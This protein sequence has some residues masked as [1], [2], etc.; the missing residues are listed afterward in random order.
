MILKRNLII[1]SFLT[2][3]SFTYERMNVKCNKE[4][5]ITIMIS[6]LHHAFAVYILC[7]F[8]FPYYKFNIIIIILTILGW[9]FNNNRCALSIY[10][11]KV[12][13]IK[14]ST[15]FYNISHLIN[16]YLSIKNIDYY[17]LSIVILL[18]LYFLLKKKSV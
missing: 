18:N 9:I 1:Y 5:L 7:S 11:N 17:V 4:T 16:N 3:L 8:L 10:Y 6:L 2:L 14:E 13:N 15:K 12:C